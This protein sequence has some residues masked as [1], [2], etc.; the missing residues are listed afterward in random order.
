MTGFSATAF[1]FALVLAAASSG[2]LGQTADR[3]TAE[4]EPGARNR[5][6]RDQAN[7]GAEPQRQPDGDETG[8][9][10]NKTDQES[11]SEAKRNEVTGQ[12]P[13][14]APPK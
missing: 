4:G 5:A 8:W 14:S 3:K 12:P 2:A 11:R 1:A 13:A 6:T 7:P 9:G 10:Q